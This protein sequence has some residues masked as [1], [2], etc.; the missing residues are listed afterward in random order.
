MQQAVAA[1]DGL[2]FLPAPP[3]KANAGTQSTCVRAPQRTLNPSGAAELFQGQLF[4][5]AAGASTVVVDVRPHACQHTQ[6]SII[7]SVLR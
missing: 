1:V 7:C 3:T 6:F 5:Y 2:G 4:A